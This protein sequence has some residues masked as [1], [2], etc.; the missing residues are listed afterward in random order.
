MHVLYVVAAECGSC[1]LVN[2]AEVAIF[3]VASGWAAVGET[4]QRHVRICLGCMLDTRVAAWCLLL[5]AGIVAVVVIDGRWLA[6]AIMIFYQPRRSDVSNCLTRE[7]W[8]NPDEVGG[9]KFDVGFAEGLQGLSNLL[10]ALPAGYIVTLQHRLVSVCE[11]WREHWDNIAALWKALLE[12]EQGQVK[13]AS[14]EMYRS[15]FGVWKVYT[16]PTA[17]GRQVVTKSLH[18][19]RM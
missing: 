12:S 17:R 3:P 5:M 13:I 6:A 8:W 19:D 10:S 18:Q 4:G 1:S 14:R 11:F 2:S 15:L 16:Q 7:L 9:S